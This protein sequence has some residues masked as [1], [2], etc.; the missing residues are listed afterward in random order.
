MALPRQDLTQWHRLREEL[1]DLHEFAPQARWLRELSSRLSGCAPIWT[2]RI[3]A[4][5]AAAGDPAD[6]DAAWQWRQ[7]GSRV[8]QALAG[9]APAELQ[10]RLEQLS[11]ERPRLNSALPRARPWRPLADNP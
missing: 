5:P 3:L 11:G 6:F 9:P 10:A 4:D 1:K 8:R 7:L 2:S